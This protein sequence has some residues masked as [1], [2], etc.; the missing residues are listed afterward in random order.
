MPRGSNDSLPASLSGAVCAVADKLDTVSGI[1][2]VG[3]LPTGSAD[4][5][6]LRRAA[7]GV[8]QILAERRW[9]LDLSKLIDFALLILREGVELKQ[10]AEVNVKIFFSQR[11]AWLLKELGIA[12]DVVSAVMH[13]QYTSLDDLIA[14]AKALDALKQE[15]SFLHL[16]IGF[17][18]VANII[19][20]QPSLDKLELSLLEPG[21]ETELYEA[22]MLLSQ[23]ITK[24]LLEQDYPLALMHLVSY[25]K[26]IDK[27]FDDVLVNCEDTAIRANRH[28]LLAKVRAEFLRV[29]DISL[30]VVDNDLIGE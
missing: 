11:V 16:V 2:G 24:A 28:V 29:A 6:A 27:F 30:I 13:T 14:R 7:G 5:F 17:K 10:A 9:N 23:D 3:M 25:G 19:A 4:P 22:L 12:Y 21:A 26:L 15:A 8:V 18:R 20:D 1:I